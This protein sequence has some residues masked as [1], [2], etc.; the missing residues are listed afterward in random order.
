MLRSCP[1]QADVSELL[2]CQGS[3]PL[4]PNWISLV[5]KPNT[6]FKRDYCKS[7]KGFAYHIYCSS[8]SLDRG[9]KLKPGK[10]F[11]HPVLLFQFKIPQGKRFSFELGSF[12]FDVSVTDDSLSKRRLFFSTDIRTLKISPL[13]AHIPL[14][15]VVDRWLNYVVD[16]ET[17]L[18]QL[19]QKKFKS[20]ERLDIHPYCQLRRIV[21][22]KT[23]NQDSNIFIPTSFDFPQTADAL[24]VVFNFHR[25]LY[26]I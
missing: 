23:R 1:F 9:I 18:L 13:H 17:I 15:V 5:S 11:L 10:S 19:Y 6:C 4:E 16:M 14:S 2:S 12:F 25:S 20:M 22:M 24:T 3:N 26:F 8:K 7:I 21:S